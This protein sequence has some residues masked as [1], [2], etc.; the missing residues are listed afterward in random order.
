MSDQPPLFPISTDAERLLTE[1][2]KAIDA[3]LLLIELQEDGPVTMRAA[4]N[5]IRTQVEA[6]DTELWLLKGDLVAAAEISAKLRSQLGEVARQR[7]ILLRWYTDSARR[8]SEDADYQKY[9]KYC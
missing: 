6:L 3:A 8:A 9:H 7:D 4:L 5:T 2:K 1:T